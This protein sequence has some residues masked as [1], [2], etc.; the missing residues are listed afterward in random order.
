MLAFKSL[1]HSELILWITPGGR[2]A[3][4]FCRWM[5]RSPA[6]FVEKAILSPLTYLGTPDPE[7]RFL[8]SQFSFPG[9]HFY[10]QAN[11]TVF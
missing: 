5:F 1:I 10:P 8:D 3:S 2:P 6:P 9:A 7:S 4:F 11:S